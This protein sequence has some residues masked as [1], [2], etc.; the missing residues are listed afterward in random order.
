MAA[1][2]YAAALVGALWVQGLYRLRT[3][4]SQRREVTDVLVAILFLAV[5]VFTTLFLVKLPNVSRLFLLLLFSCQAALTLLSRA[6]IRAV[7]VRCG[8]AATTRATC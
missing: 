5:V 8:R 1:A 2:G 3:R 7:F 4:L 6:G